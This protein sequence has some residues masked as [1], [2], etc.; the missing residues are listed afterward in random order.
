MAAPVSAW[1]FGGVPSNPNH[2]LGGH[3]GEL[4]QK[5]CQ[6]ALDLLFSPTHCLVPNANRCWSPLI[7][8]L[9]LPPVPLTQQELGICLTEPQVLKW[10]FQEIQ[11]V[12]S[13]GRF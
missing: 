8:Y 9:L 4:P 1:D 2:V 3:P 12:Q 10:F 11:T 5:Y 13:P 6:C 7:M